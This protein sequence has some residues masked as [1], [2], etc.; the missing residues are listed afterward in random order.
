MTGISIRIAKLFESFRIS[1]A[2]TNRLLQRSR[3]LRI[4]FPLVADPTQTV[5]SFGQVGFQADRLLESIYG[6]FIFAGVEI[7]F[8]LIVV[9]LGAPRGDSRLRWLSSHRRAR[10]FGCVP[11]A[12]GVRAAVTR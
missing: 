6:Q 1:R 2:I 9:G 4:F 5:M 12:A 10:A 8:T 7:L 3:G 11:R